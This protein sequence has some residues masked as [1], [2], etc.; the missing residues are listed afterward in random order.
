M[1]AIYNFVNQHFAYFAIAFLLMLWAAL[2]LFFGRHIAVWF[3]FLLTSRIYLPIPWKR[4]AYLLTS[5]TTFYWGKR[6]PRYI[7]VKYY[8][9][10]PANRKKLSLWGV[11]FYSGW[12]VLAI[13]FG[14]VVTRRLPVALGN[15]LQ[16]LILGWPTLFHMLGSWDY[17]RGFNRAFQEEQRLYKER[18]SDSGNHT[19]S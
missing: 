2:G 1:D 7:H 11:L 12:V 18:E 9:V 5:E 4:L 14:L 3:P 8:L 13:L 6:Q 15:W 17:N 16:I 10:S 19:P